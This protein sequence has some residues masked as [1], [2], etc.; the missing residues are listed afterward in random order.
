MNFIFIGKLAHLQTL[1][2]SGE[3]VRHYLEESIRAPKVFARSPTLDSESTW[4]E[5]LLRIT[6]LG[7]CVIHDDFDHFQKQ[8]LWGSEGKSISIQ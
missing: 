4:L 2:D 7:P 6:K 8:S 1:V 3:I 5:C